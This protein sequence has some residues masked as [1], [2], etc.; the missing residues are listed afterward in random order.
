M[1][2]A[3]GDLWLIDA[4][5]KCITTN[6][7]IKKNGEAVMGAGVAKE[8]AIKYPELPEKLGYSIGVNGNRVVRITLHFQSNITGGNQQI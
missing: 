5:A 8:A 4:D 2:E 1:R 7:F 6:G 3:F